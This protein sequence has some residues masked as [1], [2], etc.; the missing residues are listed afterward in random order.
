MVQRSAVIGVQPSTSAGAQRA[1]P[2]WPSAHRLS[3]QPG[4][5]APWETCG[6]CPAAASRAPPQGAR[7]A[8]GAA[9]SPQAP[10][11]P[12]CTVAAKFRG[13]GVRARAA[14]W[15]IC[16][17]CCCSNG[18]DSTA[19]R[20][21]QAPPPWCA[22]RWRGTGAACCTPP[23]RCGCLHT[24]GAGQAARA[25]NTQTGPASCAC[26]A[27]DQLLLPQPRPA[28]HPAAS[29]GA[30]CRVWAGAAQQQH[31]PQSPWAA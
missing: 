28:A 2:A 22:T 17:H 7:P 23:A 16:S 1:P 13:G 8:S 12:A 3:Q 26:R 30:E 9:R 14:A 31:R 4:Q 19:N 29:P 25:G 11:P 10:T 15:G 18:G 6:V 5:E 24:G 27:Q 21:N 20:C